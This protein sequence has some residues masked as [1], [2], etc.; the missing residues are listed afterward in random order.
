LH[1]EDIMTWI[2]DTISSRR[3]PILD[4]VS[5]MLPGATEIPPFTHAELYQQAVFTLDLL[6]DALDSGDITPLFN[7]WVAIGKACAERELSVEEIPNVPEILKRAVWHE[8]QKCVEAGEVGFADLIDAMM[9]VETILADSWFALMRSFTESED[10]ATMARNERIEALYSLTEVLASSGEGE[11]IFQ[12]I[13]EK[14]AGITGLPRCSLLLL[15]EGG[16]L[17]AAASSFENDRQRLMGAD[18]DAL[19]LL[20]AMASRSGPAVL[21]K[22]DELAPVLRALLAEYQT[23]VAL[24]VPMRAGEKALGLLLLDTGHEGEFTR[25]Q[26]D[27]SVASASQAAI[28]IEKSGLLSEME[29]RLKQMAAIGIVARTLTSHLDPKEQLESLLQMATALIRADSGVFMLLEEMFSELKEEASS[30]TAGLAGDEA[31]V[32]M[33]KWAYEAQQ[34]AP[35]HRGEP[36]DRFGSLAEPVQAC[37]VAP[38]MVRD[39]PIGIV[40]VSSSRPGEQFGKDDI[41]LFGNFAAQAAVSLE[42]TRLYQRLQDTYLGAIGSLAAAIEAR[43]P[44]T[45][46]HSARVTQY[47]VAIAESMGLSSDEVEE[48]RL[49]GLLHDLGKIGVP[50]SILNKAGRLSEE[51][52]SAIKMHPALSMRIIEPLPHLGNIIPI[53]YHHHE[54]YDGNGYMDGKA[55]DKIPLGARIIAVAD[56]FEAMTSDRPYRKA[57][58]REEAMSELSRN[59]GS[60][61]DPEVVHHFLALLEKA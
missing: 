14:V 7:K 13:V 47:A 20:A 49:A 43:D 41:E 24:V 36:D 19:G 30:G 22:N 39:K 50:D 54:R 29:G 56:S 9:E 12:S 8:L 10:V 17:E 32:R 28:A 40:G 11:D 55:G 5:D 2:A 35:W 3:V 57:L 46:G 16:K 51:E 21:D 34:L 25:E 6:V 53:I 1:R 44:Y 18:P 23:P 37:L 15:G 27:L 48:L 60:Q 33:A 52:Y 58:S 31:F 42:N 26:I 45:V 4:V 59:A 38:L 61:F